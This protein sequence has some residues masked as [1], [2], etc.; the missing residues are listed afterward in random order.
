MKQYVPNKPRPVGLKNFVV[1]TSEGII[2]DFEFYQG[3]ETNLPMENEMG[4]GPSVITRL[5]DSV[6]LQSVLYFDRYFTI[7][8]IQNLFSKEFYATE[9]MMTNRLQGNTI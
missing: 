8:L 5:K 4:L 3:K 1:T 6:P 7:S 9:T 2:I